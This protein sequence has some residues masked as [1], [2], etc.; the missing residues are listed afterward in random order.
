MP[1]GMQPRCRACFAARWPALLRRPRRR[2]GRTAATTQARRVREDVTV[3]EVEDA[4]SGERRD[5]QPAAALVS[6]ERNGAEPRGD[7]ALHGERRRCHSLRSRQRA[8]GTRRSRSGPLDR[9]PGPDPVRPRGAGA[10]LTSRDPRRSRRACRT[11]WEPE[12]ASLVL[13]ADHAAPSSRRR[14]GHRDAGLRARTEPARAA[15]RLES[16]TAA[17]GIRRPGR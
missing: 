14:S 16:A 11:V 12:A 6:G 9:T 4:M 2:P 13:L 5:H 1:S 17:V 8:R 3:E 10:R 15:L 7:R